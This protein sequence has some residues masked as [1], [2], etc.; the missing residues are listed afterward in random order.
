MAKVPNVVETLRK[1]SIAR[2]WCTNVTDRQTTNGRTT[3]YSVRSLTMSDNDEQF[4]R[5]G[6]E[7]NIEHG[8]LDWV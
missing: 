1:I 2:V 5:R 8:G 6:D 4:T 3:T 7:K